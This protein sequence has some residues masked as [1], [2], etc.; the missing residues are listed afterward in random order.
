MWVAA[1]DSPT[2]ASTL[3]VVAAGGARATVGAWKTPVRGGSHEVRYA[4]VELTGLTQRSRQWVELRQ[5]PT[6]LATATATTLP[7]TLPG[8]GEKPFTVLLSSCFASG[9]DAGGQAGIA[10]SLLHADAKPDVKVL[11]GDQVYLDAPSFWTIAPATTGDEIRRR[12]IE[13]YLAA[14]EQQPGFHSLLAEGANLFTSD[15]HDYWNNAPHWSVT[16]PATMHP[17]LR[18]QWWDAAHELYAAFQ[19]P[20][21]PG[22]ITLGMDGMSI[23]VADT[24][25]NRSE[26]QAAFMSDPDL[27]AIATWARG[28]DSPGCLVLGQLLF[29]KPAGFFGRFSDWGL[30]DFRQFPRLLDA[31]GNARHTVI[32]LTGDV[33]YGRVAVC[34]LGDGREVVEVVSSP[35]S[36]VAPIPKNTW[37]PAPA[38]YPSEAIPGRTRRPI[39]TEGGYNLNSNHFATVELS[40]GGAGGWTRLRVR[41]WPTALKGSEPEP[42]GEWI[43]WVV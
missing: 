22:T 25:T 7:G 4:R 6:V 11:C 43:H 20:M 3:E 15:D 10:Y 28:L 17:G 16:A 14:W 37:H 30:P 1:I 34:D 2:D 12:L 35:L 23:C 9:R 27:E 26:D 21:P 33:H 5:G 13:I 31:I 19:R 29:T 41:P 39:R 36:L 8:I 42:A 18:K 38:T 24:R 40:R 32:V